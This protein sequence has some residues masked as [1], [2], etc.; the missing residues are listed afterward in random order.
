MELTSVLIM[1]IWG[2]CYCFSWLIFEEFEA[3]FYT[4]YLSPFLYS[5]PPPFFHSSFPLFLF[6]RLFDLSFLSSPSRPTLC[7]SFSTLPFPSFYSF[8]SLPFLL[9]LLFSL[10]FFT[11]L[12]FFFSSFPF[13][14]FFLFFSLF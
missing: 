13:F 3:T 1:H 2:C 6:Q 9:F 7:L 4:E 11:F 14:L 8:P 12:F 10:P 5:P